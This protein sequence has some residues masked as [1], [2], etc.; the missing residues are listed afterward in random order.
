MKPRKQLKP[1]DFVEKEFKWYNNWSTYYRSSV[2]EELLRRVNEASA[3]IHENTMRGS[4]NFVVFGGDVARRVDEALRNDLTN[5]ITFG[6]GTVSEDGRTLIQ[7]ITLTPSR[8]VEEITVTI[9]P[10]T[11]GMTF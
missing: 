9:S 2:H 1:H 5:G 3:Q 8:S 10:N 6:E 7:D 11:S 4:G